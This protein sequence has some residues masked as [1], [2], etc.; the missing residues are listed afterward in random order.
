MAFN[1]GRYL[2]RSAIRLR[3]TTWQNAPILGD[4]IYTILAGIK[5]FE[6]GPFTI[7]IGDEEEEFPSVDDLNIPPFDLDVPENGANEEEPLDP[8]AEDGG[9]G[10]TTSFAHRSIFPATVDSHAGG[11]NYSVTLYPDGLAG[12]TK[13]VTAAVT[14]SS[15]AGEVELGIWVYVY[16]YVRYVV[17]QT[18]ST[19]IRPE[20]EEYL[21]IAPESGG[22]G[23]V[24]VV[25]ATIGPRAGNTAGVGQATLK[26]FDVESG[27]F[28]DGDSVQ[29]YNMVKSSIDVGAFIQVKKIDGA[30]FIDVEDCT[31]EET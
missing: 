3:R 25:T 29:V 24:A 2:F 31:A 8:E 19:E 22:G 13:T 30:W 11:V 16:R 21:F 6:T 23:K 15:K 10:T 20:D 12:P 9:G 18:G 4:E 5:D 7:I 28:S 27:S 26:P 1:L 17:T 14:D